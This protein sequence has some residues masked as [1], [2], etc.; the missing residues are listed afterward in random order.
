MHLGID[1]GKRSIAIMH[2]CS[3]A[4]ELQTPNIENTA[5]CKSETRDMQTENVNGLPVWPLRK[6]FIFSF[7]SVL[8]KK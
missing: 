3:S 5:H 8:I 6:F 1:Y 2:M 7:T 4:A